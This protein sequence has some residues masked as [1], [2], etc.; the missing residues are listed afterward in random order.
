MVE[1]DDAQRLGAVEH[2]GVELLVA[3]GHAGPGVLLGDVA[4]PGGSLRGHGVAEG[5]CQRRGQR[6]RVAGANRGPLSCERDGR[7]QPAGVGADDRG[8]AGK[9]LQHDKAESLERH[10]R[11]HGHVGGSIPVDECRVV[12]R[13][14]EPNRRGDAKARGKRSK[15][16]LVGAD[17]DD[18]EEIGPAWL[19]FPPCLE[20]DLEAHARYQPANREGDPPRR[21]VERRPCR[22][23][24]ARGEPLEVDPRLEDLDGPGRDPVGRPQDLC[25]GAREHDEASRPPVGE[26]FDG[27]LRRDVPPTRAGAR[28]LVGPGS[29]E[30]HHE[31]DRAQRAERGREHRGAREVRVG[32]V[33]WPGPPHGP[34]DGRRGGQ[35]RT[36]RAAC[37][38]DA[39]L[40]GASRLVAEHDRDRVDAHR[41]LRREEVLEVPIEPAGPPRGGLEPD[42]GDLHG[43]CPQSSL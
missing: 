11:D 29:L 31:R 14:A 17:S 3:L 8:A 39:A 5:P 2:A 36:V 15:P 26:T 40:L 10:A 16:W 37:D 27:P 7:A 1:D 43:R 21:D 19:E 6:V 9:G 35:H 42:V 22:W 25:E 32:E 18:R 41:P 12:D 24:I 33:G 23:P 38:R 34:V 28:A 4:Q 13:P 20:E 30:V